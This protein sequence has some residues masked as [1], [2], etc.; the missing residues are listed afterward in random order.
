M[1]AGCRQEMRYSIGQNTPSKKTDSE[2]KGQKCVIIYVDRFA[3]GGYKYYPIRKGQIKDVSRAHGRVYYDIELGDH[4]YSPEPNEFTSQ[5]CQNVERCP[6][7]TGDNPESNNDGEYCT[8]G[9]ELE[10]LLVS[11]GESWSSAVDQILGTR[12]FLEDA[13]AFFLAE[14]TEVERVPK[15]NKYGMI[16]RANKDYRATI[17][18]RTRGVSTGAKRHISARIGQ[19]FNREW[20]VGSNDNR[21]HFHFSPLPIDFAT[22]AISIRTSMQSP[23]SSGGDIEY[24]VEIPYRTASWRLSAILIGTL[25]GFSYVNLVIREGMEFG[26]LKTAGFALLD[27]AP[28]GILLF[29]LYTFR[30]RLKL[31]GFS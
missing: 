10:G 4:C 6:R 19:D 30:G 29:M 14:I 16:L 20:L 17:Y 2:Y 11:G 5:F 9:P 27:F 15:H 18:S 23:G 24:S 1:P 12:C 21:E 25:F 26:T 22:Y 3:E 13:P 7:L 8:E 28:F 31:P